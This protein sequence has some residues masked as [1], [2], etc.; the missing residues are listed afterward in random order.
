MR[1]GLGHVAGGPVLA[2]QVAVEQV[3]M[4]VYETEFLLGMLCEASL[5]RLP[6]EP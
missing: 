4:S 6:Q 1:G 3:E 5:N 2:L